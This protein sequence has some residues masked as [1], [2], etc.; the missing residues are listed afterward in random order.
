MQRRNL[1]PSA[2]RSLPHRDTPEAPSSSPDGLM[3]YSEK[4]LRFLAE[5]LPHI[6][7]TAL[8][9]GYIDY[10][11]ARW[12]EYTGLSMR[13]TYLELKTAVHP[14]DFPRYRQCWEDAVGLGE[15]YEIEYRFRRASDGAYRWHLGRGLP[16]RDATG[17]IVKWF[18]TCTDIHAQKEAEEQVRR[19][20][21]HLESVVEERTAHLQKEIHERRRTE[22][23]HCENLQLLRR[24]V[25]TLPMAA[26]AGDH[27]GTIL[28]ANEHFHEL[29]G[30]SE[31]E[32]L[33]GWRYNEVLEEAARRL[34]SRQWAAFMERIV[35]GPQAAVRGEV[36]LKDGRTYFIEY[37]PSVEGGAESGYLLLVR[38]ITKE[39]RVDAVKSEFMSLASHQLRTPLTSV[40]W[41]LSRLT[42]RL[43]G[44]M[45]PEESRLLEHAGASAGAMAQTIRTML[46]ISRAEAGLQYVSTVVVPLQ[47][48]L[49]G[50]HRDF[51]RQCAAKNISMSVECSAKLSVETDTFILREI[52]ENLVTNAVK[53]TP[54][55]GV[56][57][58][59][60][61]AHDDAVHLSVTDNGY[62]IPAHQ[63][64]QVF[65]KF[66]RGEN[67]LQLD[68]E[69]TGLGLY[70]VSRLAEALDA[71]ITFTSVEGQGTTF[72]LVLPSHR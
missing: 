25:N 39:K 61:E 56:V 51:E 31:E 44:R 18:G 62:G 24:M 36:A 9:N 32:T 7:W 42:K 30:L 45:G 64:E 6:V 40:R 63:H 59:S 54:E 33:R 23:K 20:N 52:L 5:S 28:Y 58:L 55:G 57:R 29:F 13:E 8:P 35:T 22:Q 26:A 41:A 49:E 69:G 27:S 43:A 67:I 21:E 72:V 15:P 47:K 53:Y 66:F 1:L 19:L 2:S 38:D 3:G 65:S 16:V 48:F 50:L 70:L 17:R 37:I 4:H 71:T 11:N 60:A 14:Q 46:S 34:P 68:T 10:M 12:F